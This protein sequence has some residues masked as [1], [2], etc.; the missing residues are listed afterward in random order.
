[1]NKRVPF[2]L[3]GV[4]AVAVAAL[5][6]SGVASAR[7]TA[8]ISCSSGMKV[9]F[10]SPLTGGGGLQGQEQLEWGQYAVKTLARPLGLKITLVPFD[11]PVEQ[12]PT[13]AQAAAEKFAGDKS[14]VAVVLATPSFNVAASSETYNQA[15]IVQVSPSATRTDLTQ[16]PVAQREAAPS[17]FR[18]VPGDYVQ[19]P[20][21]ARFMIDKLHAKK[22][23]IFDFQETYSVG[24]ADAVQAAL[25]KAGVSTIRLSAPNTTTDYSSY[26]TRVP[27]DAD[28]VFFPTQN[29]GYAQSF[30]QQLIEQGKKAKLFGADGTNDPTQFS[31][32][33]SYLSAFAPDI[34]AIPTDK[35]LIAG[36]KTD[37][38]GKPVG[39]FG[40][41]SYLAVDVV[42]HAIKLTC[43]A[44]HGRLVRANVIK[45]MRKVEIGNSILGGTFSYS[46]KSNDPHNAK[47]Y[48][49]QI[50]P[51]GS[52]KLVG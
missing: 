42:L 25:Q 3:V 2:A 43:A 39:S 44:D 10:V 46:P 24:L 15:G 16:G 49:Y 30:A 4:L 48:V 40:P 8:G 19:G 32:A 29:P 34:T 37:N 28:L 17:F 21:D 20:S 26:V 18:V 41:P 12:G 52:Y 1:M 5:A 23:V 38:P 6:A 35:S 47:F 9:G 50:Q 51:N 45:Q 11:T 14:I 27:N 31:V 13:P 33:G 36:W 22:V 7:T